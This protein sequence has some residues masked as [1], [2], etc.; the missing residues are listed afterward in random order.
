MKKS[1]HPNHFLKT[2]SW[3]GKFNIKTILKLSKIIYVCNTTLFNSS[4]SQRELF[5]SSKGIVKITL[6]FT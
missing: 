2:H 6:K 4:K 3:T 5:A 1:I